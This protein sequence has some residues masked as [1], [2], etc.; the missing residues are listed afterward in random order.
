MLSVKLVSV[1]VSSLEV[2]ADRE[3]DEADWLLLSVLE[4]ADVDSLSEVD[5]APSEVALDDSEMPLLE[6]LWSVAVLDD[7]LK[8]GSP[9][10]VV[11]DDETELLLSV[12]DRVLVCVT[13]SVKVEVLTLVSVVLKETSVADDAVERL[14]EL[15]SVEVLLD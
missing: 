12:R 7:V 13:V 4:E 15:I 8:D 3:L 10:L 9:L 11:D 1:A 2:L 5:L 6:V 14:L